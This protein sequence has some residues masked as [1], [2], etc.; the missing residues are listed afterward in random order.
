M[1][2]T[3]ALL[4]AA[5]LTLVACHEYE[6]TD[7]VVPR[8]GD[9]CGASSAAHVDI[10][11]NGAGAADVTL[12]VDLACPSVPPVF[13]SKRP[14]LGTAIAAAI[15]SG[16]P[17]RVIH[18]VTFVLGSSEGPPVL[19]RF[20]PREDRAEQLAVA[21]QRVAAM[22]TFRAARVAQQRWLADIIEAGGGRVVNRVALGN[23]LVADVP[24]GVLVDLR[25]D[26]RLRAI[27]SGVLD[28]L[29][30]PTSNGS[31]RSVLHGRQQMLADRL[32]GRT[33]TGASYHVGVVDGGVTASHDLLGGVVDLSEDCTSSIAGV[34]FGND[35]TDCTTSQ[36]SQ[37]GHGTQVAALVGGNDA[38]GPD[39][40]GVSD[41]TLDTWKVSKV[42]S[43]KTFGADSGK[44]LHLPPNQIGWYR[45][46][47][48]RAKD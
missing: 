21:A 3:P 9:P 38:Y 4:T 35:P 46:S 12:G 2:N 48:G 34:C 15:A 13:T 11:F 18:G 1:A 30:N 19:P 40:A 43:V 29:V 23:I 31:G 28:D 22:E 45:S 36:G 41:A 47:V 26:F 5:A 10:A 44:N 32:H 24:V 42:T 14:V 37:N 8:S 33:Y 7:D 17:Q 20:D 16:H 25:N 6:S 27:G 39:F